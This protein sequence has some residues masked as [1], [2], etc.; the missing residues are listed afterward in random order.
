MQKSGQTIQVE[1]GETIIDT[2]LL[3]DNL[4]TGPL[5]YVHDARLD[6]RGGGPLQRGVECSRK[7]GGESDVLMCV[8]GEEE[9]GVLDL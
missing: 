5:W 4:P 7:A 2:S 8:L 9:W 3:K 6:R 1:K